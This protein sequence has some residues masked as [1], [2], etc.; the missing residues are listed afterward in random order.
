M[1]CLASMSSPRPMQCAASRP[2]GRHLRS[3][4]S[5]PRSRIRSRAPDARACRSWTSRSA[6]VPMPRPQWTE[7]RLRRFWLEW[8]LRF[9]ESFPMGECAPSLRVRDELSMYDPHRRIRRSATAPWTQRAPGARIPQPGPMETQGPRKL[10][11]SRQGSMSA[12]GESGR[13]EGRQ[14]RSAN[15]LTGLLAE[16][17]TRVAEGVTP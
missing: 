14:R 5:I 12:M 8:R 4:R 16:R 7:T 3:G 10:R 17:A 15:S 6:L 1:P 13:S 11:A 2:D 9:G